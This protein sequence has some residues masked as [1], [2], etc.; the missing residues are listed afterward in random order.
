ML[1]EVNR[2]TGIGSTICLDLTKILNKSFIF[3]DLHTTPI[4]ARS[5]AVSLCA[6]F[7]T[8]HL[9]IVRKTAHPNESLLRI[10]VRQAGSD[11]D[12]IV[13]FR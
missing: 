1:R 7:R 10:T 9:S 4:A 8:P 12:R 5:V 3:N 2:L 6:K 13:L 11:R